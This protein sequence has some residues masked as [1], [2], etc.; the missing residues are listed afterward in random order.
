MELVHHLVC[1]YLHL[2]NQ[3]NVYDVAVISPDSNISE[4]MPIEP[5]IL[6]RHQLPKRS[7]TRSQHIIIHKEPKI[8]TF[9][10]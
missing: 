9:R 1:T 4:F 5:K 3:Q 7:M 10:H 8:I 6:E 2:W